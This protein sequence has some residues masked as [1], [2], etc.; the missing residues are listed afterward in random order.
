MQ[1]EN[2]QPENSELA[3]QTEQQISL[4]RSSQTSSEMLQK[5]FEIQNHLAY[6]R[7]GNQEF[8]IQT[9]QD[10]QIGLKE[11]EAQSYYTQHTPAEIVKAEKLNFQNQVNGETEILKNL[12]SPEVLQQETALSKLRKVGLLGAYVGLSVLMVPFLKNYITEKNPEI[13]PRELGI[14]GLELVLTIDWTKRNKNENDKR[15]NGKTDRANF[16][17]TQTR[18][19]LFE[20]NS[21]KLLQNPDLD[22]SQI[23]YMLSRQKAKFENKF[24]LPAGSV[25]KITESRVAHNVP[26]PNATPPDEVD[27]PPC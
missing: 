19:D 13:G 1:N 5:T 3:N 15:G 24:G 16:L 23:D 26:N 2:L 17:E 6:L 22:Y 25:S 11:L 18:E 14:I 10:L 20:K 9:P 8:R 7:S 4:P 12:A 27:S 21:Q